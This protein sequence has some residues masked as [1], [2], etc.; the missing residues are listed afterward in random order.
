MAAVGL[1]GAILVT[2]MRRRADGKHAHRTEGQEAGANQDLLA[3][4]AFVFLSFGGTFNFD[5]RIKHR[6]RRRTLSA[7]GC[8]V[9]KH[10]ASAVCDNLIQFFFAYPSRQRHDAP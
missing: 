1:A 3:A 7:T 8:F 9:A 6:N 2:V 4:G 5:D 10:A